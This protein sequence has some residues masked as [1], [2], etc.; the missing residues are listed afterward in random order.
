M[1]MNLQKFLLGDDPKTFLIGAGCSVDPP[2]RLP[3][4]REMIVEIIKYTCTRSEIDRL[5][6]MEN[7]R[8]EMLISILQDRLDEKLNILDYYEQSDSPNLQH[9]FLAEM[10]KRGHF[11]I[12]TNF[13]FLLEIALLRSGVPPSGIVPVITKTDFEAYNDPDLLWRQGKKAIYKLHGSTKNIITKKDTR[14]SLI[15]T[16]KAFGTNKMERNVFQIEPFKR[17]VFDHVSKDRTLVVMGYSGSDDFDII[18]TLKLLRGLKAIVWINHSEGS[19][20][21]KVYELTTSQ[22]DAPTQSKRVDQ[23]LL[24]IRQANSAIHLY[25][26]ETNTAAFVAEILN[27]PLNLNPNITFTGLSDWLKTHIKTPSAIEM[28]SIP[29]EIFYNLSYYKEALRCARI[30]LHLAEEANN[31]TQKCEALIWIGMTYFNQDFPFKALKHYEAALQ[32]AKQENLPSLQA[33]ILSNMSAIYILEKREHQKGREL[34]EEALRIKESQGDIMIEDKATLLCNIGTVYYNEGD[35]STALEYYEEARQL[36]ERQEV[37][38]LD[39]RANVYAHI[40]SIYRKNKNLPEA[41]K[42]YQLAYQLFDNLGDIF[43]KAYI[44]DFLGDIYQGQNNFAESLK[45]FQEALK[46]YEQVGNSE[47]KAVTLLGIS[48]IHLLRGEDSNA[49][50]FC[51][52]A[53]EIFSQL[54]KKIPDIFLKLIEIYFT[55]HQYTEAIRLYEAALKATNDLLEKAIFLNS[56]A[57]CRML[58]GT[59]LRKKN[60]YKAAVKTYQKAGR[61]FQMALQLSGEIGN[62]LQRIYNLTGLGELSANQGDYIKAV[63]YL[64]E[65]RQLS[66]ELSDIIQKAQVY[67][68]IGDIYYAMGDYNTALTWYMKALPLSGTSQERIRVLEGVAQVKKSQLEYLHTLQYLEEAHQILIKQEIPDPTKIKEIEE[69]IEEVKRLIEEF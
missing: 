34:L 15:A 33:D 6:R 1:D 3:T 36:L 60:K 61:E 58:Q 51:N 50:I 69:K 52:K 45:C 27:T 28:V 5:L 25:R 8:F 2:S 30:C 22:L 63:D 35:T 64:Q 53:L 68:K 55:R 4:G 62:E 40:G 20:T 17:P 42:W 16:I 18:P 21:P 46:I 32:I 12:T 19:T 57:K 67:R 7:L 44:S 23:I 43:K 38:D 39:G 26:V 49:S 47:K 10:V 37:G 24:E 66:E 56:M 59:A 54:G 41:L 31:P 65:A 13:D 9:F 29:R 48:K 14:D 11:V